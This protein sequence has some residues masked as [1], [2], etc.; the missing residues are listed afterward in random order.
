MKLRTLYFKRLANE[1]LRNITLSS[2]YNLTDDFL[3]FIDACNLAELKAISESLEG[4]ID[5]IKST[6]RR[7]GILSKC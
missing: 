1:K 2:A 3:R 4:T 7:K 6:N 5:F